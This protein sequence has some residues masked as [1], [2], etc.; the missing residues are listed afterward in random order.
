MKL[1]CKSIPNLGISFLFLFAILFVQGCQPDSKLQTFEFSAPESVELSDNSVLRFPFR[2]ND[3][4][5][6]NADLRIYSNGALVFQKELACS[7]AQ[8]GE[9]SLFFFRHGK[10]SVEVSETAS[11][12]TEASESYRQANA[13]PSLLLADIAL[14][15][16]SGEKAMVLQ[17]IESDIAGTIDL[18]NYSAP[19]THKIVKINES[20]L[21]GKKCIVYAETY[22]KKGLQ[23]YSV[24]I[25]ST[26]EGF[27]PQDSADRIMIL[28][29]VIFS[30]R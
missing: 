20:D 24:Q 6:L 1:F 8:S 13:N 19:M 17:K 16:S 10:P 26:I 22:V 2:S 15:N 21:R 11:D 28:L 9:G 12:G 18:K 25:P 7:A 30:K 3:A 23:N 5:S 27:K 29:G 4:I 14:T